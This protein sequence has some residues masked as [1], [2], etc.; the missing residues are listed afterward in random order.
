LQLGGLPGG[1]GPLGAV[2]ECGGDCNQAFVLDAEGFEQGALAVPHEISD[3]G[4]QGD[5]EQFFH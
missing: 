4:N 2:F 3:G 5:E 1:F